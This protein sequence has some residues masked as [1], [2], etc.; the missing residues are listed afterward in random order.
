MPA[1]ARVQVLQLRV[2]VIETDAR[3]HLCSAFGSRG[4]VDGGQARRNERPAN[5][6]VPV[7]TQARL[8]EQAGV[9]CPPILHVCAGFDIMAGERRGCGEIAGRSSV[10]SLAQIADWSACHGFAEA[11]VVHIDSGLQIVQ[12]SPVQRR[13]IQRRIPFDALRSG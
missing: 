11:D 5:N 12:S 6:L 1:S 10:P 13:Q 3:G 2:L 9:R 4:Q 7:E 8:D